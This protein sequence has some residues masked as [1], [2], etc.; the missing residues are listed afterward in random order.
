MRIWLDAHTLFTL[1]VPT[2][3]TQTAVPQKHALRA[4]GIPTAGVLVLA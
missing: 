1:T 4:T 3:Y 2:P